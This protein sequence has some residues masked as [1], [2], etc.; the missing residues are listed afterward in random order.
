ML[1][2]ERFKR[3]VES[4]EMVVFR[5]EGVNRHL[6]FRAPGT[7]DMHFDVVTW[8]G[9]LCYTGDMGTY[10]FRRT[11][12]ML[13]FFRPGPGD[14][15]YQIDFRYW[16]E[17]VESSDRYDGLAAFSFKKFKA[18]VKDYVERATSDDEGWTPERLA[19]LWD[20]IESDVFSRADDEGPGVAWSAL[21]DFEHDGFQFTDWEDDC[22]EYSHRF[23]WCC[24]ALEWAVRTYDEHHAQKESEESR[25]TE[26]PRG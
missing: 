26:A 15:P 8:P 2:L 17:K 11:H 9:Y 5:D 14:K 6:R 7:M 23:L 3:D 22:K 10:V 4:H 20:E 16:A 13:G 1:N 19:L 21:R 18:A 24:H 25:T 12:D